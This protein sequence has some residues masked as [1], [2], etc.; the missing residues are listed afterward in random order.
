MIWGDNFTLILIISA[1]G[2]DVAMTPC[3]FKVVY[4]PAGYFMPKC[5][6][7]FRGYRFQL[8]MYSSFFCLMLSQ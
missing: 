2:S 1:S 8:N 7:S 4:Y 6:L 3:L 5:D